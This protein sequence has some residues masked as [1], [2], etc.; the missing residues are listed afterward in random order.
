MDAKLVKKEV[1]TL[2]LV[3]IIA[4][5]YAQIAGTRMRTTRTS[6]L[7]RR[8]FLFAINEIFEEV[9]SSYKSEYKSLSKKSKDK[10]TFVPKNGK[11][12]SVFI[13]ANSGLY[14]DLVK[15]ISEGFLEEVRN[16]GT[17]AVIIGRSG[18]SYFVESLKD[19]PYT[20][21][22]F[23]DARLDNEMLGKIVRHLVAYDEIHIFYGQYKSIINQAPVVFKISSQDALPKEKEDK[24][25][26]KYLFEPDLEEI[27]I[28]F[29]KEMFTSLLEQTLSESQLAKFASRMF[30]MEE[31]AR[32]IKENLAKAKRREAQLD[33]F[34]D[35]KKQTNLFS[36]MQLW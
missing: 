36:S 33:H 24:E 3:E 14:G 15:R 27:L 28:F 31:A 18:L 20:Y 6:V 21:F 8:E 16:Q 34:L 10:I 9:R 19:H 26:V 32:K 1:E 30:S 11:I 23:P 25:V 12:V 13:S 4:K 17:E 35:N 22:D 5:S 29:E 7:K 2:M